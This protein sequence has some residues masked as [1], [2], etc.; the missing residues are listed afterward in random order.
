MTSV[1]SSA[2]MEKPSKWAKGWFKERISGLTLMCISLEFASILERSFNLPPLLLASSIFCAVIFLIPFM[3]A[4]L[5]ST[6]ADIKLLATI[7]VL[8]AASSPS[9]S[10]HGFCSERPRLWASSKASSKVLPIPITVSTK[11]QVPLSIPSN[12]LMQHPGKP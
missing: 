9:M 7:T 6:F 5:R 11:L 12:L 10:T 3:E 2:P 8:A 4:C 1:K